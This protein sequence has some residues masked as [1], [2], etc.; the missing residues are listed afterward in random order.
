MRAKLALLLSLA[1]AVGVRADVETTAIPVTSTGGGGGAAAAI[2][3]NSTTVTGCQNRVLY[4][5]N[6][7]LVNCEAAFG[8]TASTDTLTVPTITGAS[9]VLEI[10][11]GATAQSLRVYN[12]DP[13]ANDEFGEVGFTGPT[14]NTFT[15]SSENAASGTVRNMQFWVNLSTGL[16]TFR[17]AGS[18]FFALGDTATNVNNA[19]GLGAASGGHLVASRSL[20]G[21]T[22]KALTESAATAIVQVAVPS[23]DH[24]GGKL[25]YCIFASDATD[26]Q[27]RCSDVRFAA[28]NKAGTETC[29]MSPGTVTE[30][31][32]SNAAAISAGTLTYAITCTTTPTNAVQ[33]EVNAVSSLTQTT[34]SAEW[35]VT[36]LKVQ[37]VTAQ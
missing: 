30:A 23:G 21:Q 4:G 3:P 17:L 31:L 8:Y 16:F 10:K 22:T 7:S 25:H 33:F 29:T 14:A 19:T 5:D 35:F 18:N 2:T 9:D 20:Q 6:S 1:L 34:L 36:L 13:G 27:E 11:N 37:T 28:V 24:T 15:V 32:D 12:T 26:H